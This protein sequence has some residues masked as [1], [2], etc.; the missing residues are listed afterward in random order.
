MHAFLITGATKTGRL[1][2]IDR[3]CTELTISRHDRIFIEPE[4][5]SIGIAQVRTLERRLVLK[6]YLSSSTA[7]IIHDAHS[8]TI[9]AQQALLKTLEEPPTHSLIFLETDNTSS[10]LPTII[11]RCQLKHLAVHARYSQKE[12]DSCLN[13]LKQLS[14]LSI[15]NRARLIENIASSRD[16]AKQWADLALYTMHRI[17][18]SE[19][20]VHQS[21]F[22]AF[23]DSGA[24]KTAPLVRSL[25][26]AQQQLA[27]NVYPM[28]VLD[29]VFLS[30]PSP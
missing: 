9:E 4:T 28:L 16:N 24:F 21:F 18:L 6:P 5:S 1:E 29:S 22:R 23:Q 20:R 7:A 15:G 8:L 19:H 26:I 13:I 27:A 14:A 25:I 2:E 30:S 11:S 17:M 10:L 12:I 3:L